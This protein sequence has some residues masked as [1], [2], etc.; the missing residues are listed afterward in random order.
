VFAEFKSIGKKLTLCNIKALK[1]DWLSIVDH[2][3]EPRM[4]I[5]CGASVRD[6]YWNIFLS[7]STIC[8][9]S[10]LLQYRITSED[11]LCSGIRYCMA[12]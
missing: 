12:K 6:L 4:N 11:A 10:W 3:R 1:L 9:F 7:S 5:G 8:T 2:R